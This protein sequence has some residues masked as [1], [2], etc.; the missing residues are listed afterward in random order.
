[1]SHQI[2]PLQHR[3]HLSFRY[4]GL[5]DATRMSL[6]PMTESKVIRRC[7]KVLDNFDKSLKLPTLFWVNNP[8]ENAWVCV[9]QNTA[10]YL[11]L[12]FLTSDGSLLLLQKNYK[13]WYCIPPTSVDTASD[14][15]KK[16]K[17]TPGSLLQRKIP[18][19]DAGQ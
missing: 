14:G 8:P 2:Q 5:E 13:T 3:Q 15:S 12:K 19:I 16:R 6:E 4:E 11:Y 10:E 18:R 9:W 17:T 7:C 1:M